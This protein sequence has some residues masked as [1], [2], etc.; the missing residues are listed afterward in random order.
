MDLIDRF[1]LGAL[2]ANCRVSA[3]SL[4]KNLNISPTSVQNRITKLKK[5]GGISRGYVFLS[6]AMLDADYCMCWISTDATETDENVFREI[7]KHPAVTMAISGSQKKNFLLNRIEFEDA[8]QIVS[9]FLSSLPPDSQYDEVILENLT[10]GTHKLTVYSGQ[11][12]NGIC[13]YDTI[14]F[15]IKEPEITEIESEPDELEPTTEPVE[16]V[17]TEVPE[18][19]VKKNQPEYSSSMEV[20]AIIPGIVAE[21]H[22]REGQKVSAGDVLITLEAMKMYNDIEAEVKGKV[23]EVNVKKGDKVTK[24][25]LMIK[26]T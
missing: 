7:G 23:A 10:E 18:E 4:S 8:N 20:R 13:A 15:T 21:L 2:L 22:V 5:M 9:D 17:T 14:Y 3:R 6:L 11:S 24:N 19:H 26:L 12:E 16:P 25:Q 1:I